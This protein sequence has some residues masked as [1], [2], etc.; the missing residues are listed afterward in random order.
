MPD[1]ADDL[2]RGIER[3]DMSAALD[4][5]LKLAFDDVVGMPDGI[6]A[7]L[8]LNKV[9]IL[10]DGGSDDTVHLDVQA[11]TEGPVVQIGGLSYASYQVAGLWAVVFI[12]PDVNVV[13]AG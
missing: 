11:W 1:L 12:D 10:I 5:E 8:D 2:F 7:F 9:Q 13:F 4:N 6:D 3:I